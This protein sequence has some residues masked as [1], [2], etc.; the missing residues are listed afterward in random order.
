M[1]KNKD[2]LNEDEILSYVR[3]NQ[4]VYLATILENHPKVR[5]MTMFYY[6][7]R[8][9]MVTFINDSKVLQIRNNKNIE[10][11]LPLKEEPNRDGY[12][13]FSGIAKIINDPSLKQEATYF[14]Y[15]FDEFWDG[16]DDPE[17]CLLELIFDSYEYMMPGNNHKVVIKA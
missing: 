5:P 3:D 13:R 7:G 12:I 10:V 16:S 4:Y 14:C 8:Y 1:G 15:F 9:F 11:I 2:Y 17:F 6:H